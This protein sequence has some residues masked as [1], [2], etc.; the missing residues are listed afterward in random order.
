M[1]TRRS[2]SVIFDTLAHYPCYSQNG[3][4]VDHEANTFPRKFKGA[5]KGFDIYG[6]VIIDYSI[7]S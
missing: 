5:A 7:R 1:G 2:V 6:F 3:Y 4:F